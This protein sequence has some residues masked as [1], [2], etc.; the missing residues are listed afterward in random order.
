[1]QLRIGL[2]LNGVLKGW[3]EGGDIRDNLM[4]RGYRH[5]LMAGCLLNSS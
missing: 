1:M 2:R 5:K 3:K 4:Q